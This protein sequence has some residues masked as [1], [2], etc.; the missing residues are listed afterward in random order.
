[1]KFRVAGRQLRR[2][3][4]GGMTTAEYA[5]GTVAVVGFGGIL[6]KI[7]IDPQVQE[8]LLRLI[9]Y[10]IGLIWGAAGT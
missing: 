2:P 1:M 7:L 4:E 10:L 6:A 3:D 5:I 9:A 8:L